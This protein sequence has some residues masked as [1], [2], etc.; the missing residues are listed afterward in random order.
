MTNYEKTIVAIME[1]NIATAKTAALRADYTANLADFREYLR[2]RDARAALKT[3]SFLDK[4]L[5]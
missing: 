4:F 1:H 3:P 5:R 2:R